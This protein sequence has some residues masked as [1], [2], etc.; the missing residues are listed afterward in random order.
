MISIMLDVTKINKD[1]LYVGKK[2]TYLNCVLIETPN[3]EYGDYMI[4]EDISYQERM[5]GKRGTILGNGKI[6]TH[7]GGQEI[8][9]SP[10]SPI[11]DIQKGEPTDLPF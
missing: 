4:V 1:R 7:V 3:S 5:D 8:E 10:S 11:D 6:K 9:S 2:G